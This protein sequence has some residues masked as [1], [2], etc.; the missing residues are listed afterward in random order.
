MFMLTHMKRL[1]MVCLLGLANLGSVVGS[2][3]GLETIFD[4]DGNCWKMAGND[5]VVH[6]RELGFRWL[7]ASSHDAARTAQPGL[8]WTDLPVLEVVARFDQ[9][10]LRELTASLY[11]RGDA[12][13]LSE[14]EFQKFITHVDGVLTAWTGAKGVAFNPQERTTAATLQRKSWIKPP[15]RIDLVWS[16][17][18]KS[19]NQGVLVPRPEFARLQ[20]TQFDPAHDPRKN[21][22][23]TGIPNQSKVI[24][25]LELKNRVNRTSTGDVLIPTVPMVDQGQK[26]Y[27]AAAVAERVL[28][29]YGRTLDQHEI[30]QLANTT[31]GHGTSPEQMVTALRRISDETHMDVTVFHD[32]NTRE[33]E[34]L[35]AD[36]NRAAKKMRQPEIEFRHRQGNNIILESPT[37]VYHEMDAGLLKEVRGKHDGALADFKT[38]IAKCINNGVPLAWGC[39]VGV[40]KENPNPTGFGGHMRLIIGY[41][42]RTKEILYTDTWGAGHELKRLPLTDAWTITLG[43]YCLQ[44]RDVHF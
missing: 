21:I 1:L 27:C 9:T 4:S 28:R 11:N 30:A 5:F 40:V 23:A 12:G 10:A 7:S 14:G 25:A 19:R 43:L 26:G 16:C 3:T 6:Y 2:E 17:S 32:F 31:A 33:F 18:E 24:T 41:N 34:Q 29:Y 37:T 44:P 38:T 13:E 8:T 39:V 22:L 20:I 35:M 36:Y 15:H 42:D